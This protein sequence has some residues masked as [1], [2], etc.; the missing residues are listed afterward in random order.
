M[1]IITYLV[2]D[3]P[4]ETFQIISEY[5][6]QKISTQ[7]Q[8]LYEWRWK[9]PTPDRDPFKDGNADIGF[10]SCSSFLSASDSIELCPVAPVY[11]HPKSNGEPV[12]FSE[13]VVRVDAGF[14]NDNFDK[15]KGLRLAFSRPDSSSYARMLSY[16]KTNNTDLSFFSDVLQSGSYI[17]SI[18]M[19]LSGK[20]DVTAVDSRFF[21]NFLYNHPVY[22]SKIKVLTSLGPIAPDPIVFRKTL[23]EKVKT[24]VVEA[25]RSMPH[26]EKWKTQMEYLNIVKMANIDVN[27]L[28]K[29]KPYVDLVKDLS[30]QPVYY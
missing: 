11:Q 13:V 29:Q 16:L 6:Q 19:I 2:P 14:N 23:P 20:A 27:C 15:M 24:A 4:V 1:N 8:L 9:G 30:H 18:Q 26:D 21:Q 17:N 3:I 10:V 25:L 12:I 7:V 28:N 5:L 22:K